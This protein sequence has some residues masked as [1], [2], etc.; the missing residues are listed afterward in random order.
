MNGFETPLIVF[1]VFSQLSIGL[2]CV[3]A[4]RQMVGAE[5]HQDK[6]RTEW[7]VASCVLVASM[8][9]SA[10]H[11]G[12]P[13]GMIKALTHLGSAWLSR[14]AL[15][16]GILLALLVAGILI[17]RSKTNLGLVMLTALVGLLAIYCMGMTYSPPSFPALNNVLP[18]LFFLIT[19]AL[20]GSAVGVLFTPEAKKPLVTQIL[21]VSLIVGLVIYLVVPCIWL[22]GGE[23]M[24]LSG[25]S[26]ISSPLYW[27]RVLVGLV[28]PLAI[29]WATKKIPNWLWLVILCGELAGRAV[30]FA[31]TV[32]SA[33]NMGG[34][35]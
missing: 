18:F 19:A 22:S 12:H 15:S 34:V 7:I 5:A 27:A 25:Q 31:N 1:T 9:A 24:R 26:W 23:V 33:T 30:F 35:Y 16:V 11:L 28:L 20:L 32:H 3:R 21:L 2:V 13:A 14:E 10:F 29:I 8:L 17:M 4:V 6:I